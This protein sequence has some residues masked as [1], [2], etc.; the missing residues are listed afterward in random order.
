VRVYPARRTPR[1]HGDMLPRVTARAALAA[2][3]LLLLSPTHGCATRQGEL[4][5][6]ELEG[7]DRMPRRWFR[8]ADLVA[9]GLARRL[10]KV[11]PGPVTLVEFEDQTPITDVDLE[12]LQDRVRDAVRRAGYDVADDSAP[13]LGR[14]EAASTVAL[15]GSVT[16]TRNP[17]LPSEVV[18]DLSAALLERSET[19]WST[20]ASVHHRFRVMVA[21]A[22][23]PPPRAPRR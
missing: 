14:V 13:T 15:V 2:L 3:P 20:R 4:E 16:E 12:L 6:Q 22:P 18:L 17:A 8:V 7:R 23:P 11:P 9:D 5:F 10:P 19:D 21:L 1:T